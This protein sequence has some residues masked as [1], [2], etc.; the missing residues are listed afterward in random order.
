ME[1]L[2]RIANNAI[3]LNINTIINEILRDKT[4]QKQIISLNINDQLFDKGINSRGVNL[5]KIGGEYSINTIEGVPGL[6][7]GKKELGLPFDHITLFNEGG[8]YNSF[9]I[10][11]FTTYFEISADP[12]KGSTNLFEEWGKDI[13]GL[14]DENLQIVGQIFL[15]LIQ[16]KTLIALLK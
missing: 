2:I 4:I 16:Q 9:F 5:E 14:T 12:W 13:V 11:I 1:A 7:I 8:F 10:A 3:N 15:P 6:F